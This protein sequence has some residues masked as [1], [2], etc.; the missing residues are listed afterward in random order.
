MI[1]H[2]LDIL[3]EFVQQSF[4]PSLND[5][6]SLGFRCKER[7]NFMFFEEFAGVKHCRKQKKQKNWNLA[8][9]MVTISVTEYRLPVTGKPGFFL[10]LRHRTVTNKQ[11][12]KNIRIHFIALLIV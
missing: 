2:D 9:V 6:A 12:T 3:P 7:I 11:K 1:C 8:G 5:F 10:M 4:L